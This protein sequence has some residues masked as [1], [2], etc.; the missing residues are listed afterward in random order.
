MRLDGNID[1]ETYQTKIAEVNEKLDELFSKKK[2]LND[3]KKDQQDINKRLTD[4]QKVISSNEVL[5]G[6]DRHVFE[7]VVD[8]VIVGE[9]SEDG[10]V[11]PYKLK[12]IFKTGQEREEVANEQP[13][14]F[15]DSCSHTDSECDIISPQGN[16]DTYRDGCFIIPQKRY[17]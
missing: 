15:A 10:T 1:E 6:F 5:K 17:T 11:N 13:F 12:F 3:R 4:F 16:D 14:S 2:S 9:K 8:K 7:S